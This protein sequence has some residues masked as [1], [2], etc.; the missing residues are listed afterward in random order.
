MRII[1]EIV[2]GFPPDIILRLKNRFL[3][4]L[5][6]LKIDEEIG[7]KIGCTFNKVTEFPALNLFVNQKK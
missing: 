3:K 1:D 4:P 5:F 6:N 7:V 2:S